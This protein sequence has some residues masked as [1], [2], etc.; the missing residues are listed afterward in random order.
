MRK[1][2]EKKTNEKLFFLT[3]GAV[4]VDRVEVDAMEHR[5]QRSENVAGKVV[6]LDGGGSKELSVIT[7]NKARVQVRLAKRLVRRA[8]QQEG[9]VVVQPDNLIS[10]LHNE[11]SV[12]EGQNETVLSL[13]HLR[14]LD[15]A[16]AA[17]RCD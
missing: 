9:N 4:S 8:A 16:C 13:S 12:R 1:Q 7:R 5:H 15:E 17:L 10:Y 6:L 2:K 14:A 11:K 3:E